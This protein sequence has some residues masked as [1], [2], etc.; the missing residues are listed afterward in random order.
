MNKL[1]NSI[2]ILEKRKLQAEIAKSIFEEMKLELGITKAKKILK[3]KPV[4][5]F[6]KGLELIINSALRK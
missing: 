1:E 4:I 5:E 2:P 3:W 6:N